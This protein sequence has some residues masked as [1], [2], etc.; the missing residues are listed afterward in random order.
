MVL[1]RVWM[2]MVLT[3]VVAGLPVGGAAGT[4]TA[5]TPTDK[6]EA[7][8]N[9]TTQ[10]FQTTAIGMAPPTA[11]NPQHGRALAI[12]AGTILARKELLAIAHGVVIDSQ[13]RVQALMIADTTTETRVSGILRGAQV[14]DV[15]D[16]GGGAVE[17]TVAVAATGPFADL[18]LPRPAAPG[19]PGPGGTPP[20]SGPGPQASPPPMASPVV[21]S[22]LVT[23]ARGLGLKPAMAPKVVSE[24]GQ[25]IYGSAVVDREWAI[26]QGMVG[27]SKDLFAAQSSPR[28]G[29]KPLV[30]KGLRAS[31][32]NGCDVVLSNADA[33]MLLAATGNLSF[34]EKAK[35]MVVVD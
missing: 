5:P 31:G 32:A 18:V 16:L 13:S 33:V 27:Y 15:R 1:R 25:E 22:G 14:A 20:V 7:G 6:V 35:V 11:L 30:V 19:S 12:E 24:S 23:D 26:Q 10:F 28:V 34:L 9:W 17:V 21:Y 8:V 2:M 4:W 3:A 29:E